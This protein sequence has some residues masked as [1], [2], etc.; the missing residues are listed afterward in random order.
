MP[1]AENIQTMQAFL[2]YF[3]PAQAQRM[4]RGCRAP[5]EDGVERAREDQVASSQD[6]VAD[7][8]LLL[9]LSALRGAFPDLEIA[10][11]DTMVKGDRVAAR[12]VVTNR[13]AWKARAS[14]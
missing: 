10:L 7:E 12:L 14:A 9:G 5:T 3:N 2:G 1:I 4:A 8:R 6:S 13:Q 11:E